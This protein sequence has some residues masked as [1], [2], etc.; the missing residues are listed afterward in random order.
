MPLLRTRYGSDLLRQDPV[1][2][3]VGVRYPGCPKLLWKAFAEDLSR[4]RD[5]LCATKRVATRIAMLVK[6]LPKIAKSH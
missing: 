1:G 2:P 6:C 3:A 4:V 5:A